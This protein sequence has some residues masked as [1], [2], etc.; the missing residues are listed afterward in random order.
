MRALVLAFTM[1]FAL[2]GTALPDA[3]AAEKPLSVAA[4]RPLKIGYVDLTRVLR[5]YARRQDCEQDLKNSQAALVSREGLRLAVT[6]HGDLL[7]RAQ[8]SQGPTDG[9]RDGHVFGAAVDHGR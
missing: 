6:K 8:Q 5:D 7:P 3:P 2:G 1:V 9:R 4:A